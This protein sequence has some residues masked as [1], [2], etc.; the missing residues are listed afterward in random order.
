VER[1][2]LAEI[3]EDVVTVSKEYLPSIA[4]A[5]DDPRVE[6]AIG[7]GAEYLRNHPGEFDA[8][9]SDSPDPVGPGV[10]LFEDPYFKAAKAALRG[11]GLFVTQC[12]SL[13]VHADTA[14]DVVRRLGLHFHNALPYVSMIPTYP[15]GSWGFVFASETLDPRTQCDAARQAEIAKST[16]YYTPAHQAGAFA[17]PAFFW[18]G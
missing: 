12:E 9:F 1:V 4:G 2:V 3:D 11:E 18:K 6:I 15:S 8:V 17:V 14:R 13:W 5:L 16:R 10:V 7:D